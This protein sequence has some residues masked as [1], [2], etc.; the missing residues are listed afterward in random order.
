MTA[1]TAVTGPDGLLRCSWATSAPDYIAYHDLE[2]G[3]PIRD[4]RGLFERM[5]LEAFQSGLSWL[6]I[7]RKRPAFRTAF[8]GFDIAAVAGFGDADVHRLL[9]DAGIVRN[10]AKINA[11]I[12]N[13]R[14]AHDLPGGLAALL[15]S[16]APD[17]ATRPA[18]CTSA[19]VPATTAESKAMA[20]AL[21][22]NGFTFVGPT[23]CYALM[24]AT[25]MVDDHLLECVA[26]GPA[27][28]DVPAEDLSAGASSVKP[29][30]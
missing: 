25:G 1:V 3:R 23:T 12:R 24:Q 27:A 22:R 28:G 29:R 8:A 26:R 17:P 20:K 13:A 14:A 16:F 21:K 7:L 30:E 6:T 5:T 4:D 2:W 19:D 15:W 18:P 11:A 10:T 9:A